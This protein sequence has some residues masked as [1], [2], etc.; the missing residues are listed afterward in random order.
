MAMAIRD[1]FNA[2]R[3]KG[4][5]R[6]DVDGVRALAVLAVVAYHYSP[7]NFPGGFIGVDVFFVISGYLITGILLKAIENNEFSTFR[8]MLV[9]FYQRRIRRIFPSLILVLIA[10]LAIGW[11]VLFSSEY[12]R[13][14]KYI[15]AGAGYVENFTL[16]SEA[17]YFDHASIDKTLLH[18]WSLSVEE[19]FYIAWPLLLWLITRRRWSLLRSIGLIAALTFVLNV[20]LVLGGHITHAFYSPLSRTWELMVGAWL[21]A[22]HRQGVPWL[23]RWRSAQSWA[24]I[25]LIMAALALIEP[26]S[27][28]P[29]F[30]A[31]LPVLGTALIVNAGSNTFLNRRVLSWR[32]A[33]WVGL[34]SYPLYLWHWALLSLVVIVF[35]DSNPTFRHASRLV[36]VV[37][38]FLLAWLTYRYF[39]DPIRRSRRRY[40]ALGLTVA[41]AALG[42]AGL[43]VY[44]ASGLPDRPASFVSVRAEQY[45]KS[46][47]MGTL[48]NSQECF[49][50]Q[51]K[52]TLLQRQRHDAYLPDKWYCD[53]G[54]THS[55]TLVLAYGDSH[56]RAMIPTLD[57]YGKATNTRVIFSSIGSC[58][59]L[60]NVTVRT[61]YPDACRELGDKATRLA[62]EM[63]PKAV[64]LIEAWASYMGA[65]KIHIQRSVT[66]AQ[67][68][69]TTLSETLAIYQALDI[70]VVLVQDNP[71]QRTSVPKAS[72]RFAANPS[73]QRLNADA[74]TR[75]GYV[76]QQAQANSI[77]ESVAARYPLSSVLEV[78]NALCDED[79][80]PWATRHEFLYY[81]SDHLSAAGALRVYPAFV[82]HMNAILTRGRAG[83]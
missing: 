70:P 83:K 1:V 56:A 25:A 15:A 26:T 75:L 47:Q 50:P 32:P 24:G 17:G 68:L 78:G 69:R 64:V 36:L 52:M 27:A 77:L 38:S 80:C 16:W 8:E 28:F 67:A 13:L 30:W 48:A 5:Y 6:P 60:T 44:A 58:L 74:V 42:V 45:V 51:T 21:A 79:I 14:G 43:A 9:D 10:C 19:Q 20:S 18:L 55:K 41:V 33:V 29:G 53:I 76:R 34:I 7:A 35:G 49:N 61:D 62:S 37:A 22:G 57:K 71:H 23:A 65:G 2:V 73:D 81:D 63:R 72:I 46:M 39:E 12:E 31:L 82:A 54:D 11:L 40:T 4:F 3:P 59:P 66:G